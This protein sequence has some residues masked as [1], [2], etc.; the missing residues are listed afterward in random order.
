MHIAIQTYDG[1]RHLRPA[2]ASHII[3]RNEFLVLLECFILA[4]T[5]HVMFP[6][7]RVSS[8]SYSSY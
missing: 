2:V 8:T 1:S 4:Y 6:H 7:L 3:Q 5:A